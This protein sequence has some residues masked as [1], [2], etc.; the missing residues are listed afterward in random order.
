MKINFKHRILIFIIIIKVFTFILL[1][2]TPGVN[3]IKGFWGFSGAESVDGYL[4]GIENFIKTG[5]YFPDQRMPGYGLI[6]LIPRILFDRA[7][8]SNI[9]IVIQL[10][11]GI[12]SAYLLA[13]ISYRIF[14][15]KFS[16]VIVGILYSLCLS[17]SSYE[18]RIG[19][20]SLAISVS[21]IGFYFFMKFIE[22]NKFSYILICALLLGWAIFIRPIMG[23]LWGVVILNLIFSFFKSK[24][25][26]IFISVIIFLLPFVLLESFWITRN[27]RKHNEFNPLDSKH[28]YLSDMSNTKS[29]FLYPF[30]FTFVKSW[31]GNCV[32]WDP[33]SE[34]RWFGV[35]NR[36]IDGSTAYSSLGTYNKD[37]PNYI[38]TSRFNKDS[39]LVIQSKI[40]QIWS[41]K[42][43]S[44]TSYQYC[45]F[46]N[47]RLLLYSK[48]IQHERPFVYYVYAPLRIIKTFI[49]THGT[50]TLI[51][52]K[53][54]EMNVFEKFA[55]LMAMF[56]NI[57][58]LTIGLISILFLIIK[59]KLFG[60]L[61]IPI[62]FTIFYLFFIGF[63]FKFPEV[64]FL[65]PLYPFL[66]LCST[67]ILN[68]VA[69]YLPTS[70][71]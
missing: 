67:S 42:L 65:A 2:S 10:I 37:L 31:G 33:N 53:F 69:K 36:S 40:Q 32:M 15:T 55:K 24:S 12:L 9:L 51:N 29:N 57:L 3:I 48:S 11:L 61:F 30:I 47:T 4:L 66:L 70:L 39:L 59:G 5:S 16:F 58:I 62:S 13:D 45:D 1:L 14:K 54:S 28:L 6:Y 64:R 63:L 19:A 34:V 56:V 23:V 44:D 22:E 27:Y 20:D 68:I 25:S 26:K 49:F 21:I 17:V 18:I 38:Y 7:I 52:K 60:S 35:E 8:A 46:V 41:Q 43:S 50:Q 71:K